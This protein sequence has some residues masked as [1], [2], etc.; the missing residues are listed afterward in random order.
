MPVLHD[1]IEV[2][3]GDDWS[4][5]GAL[6]NEDGT[7]LDLTSVTVLWT[8]LDPMGKQAIESGTA[9]VEIQNPPTGGNVIITVPNAQTSLPAGRYTDA[10][11]VII[12]DLRDTIWIGSILV[13]ADP[14]A[15]GA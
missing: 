5:S 1:D 4:I 14:F 3:A 10:V 8:L 12:Q 6:Q 15:Q 9:V 11:R 2:I 13:G 7:P